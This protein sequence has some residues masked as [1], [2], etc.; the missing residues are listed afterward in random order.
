MNDAESTADKVVNK[1]SMDA[2]D[3]TKV[4]ISYSHDSNHHKQRVLE[5]SDSLVN[6]GIFCIL[7]QYE[8]AP[9]DGWVKWMA[10]SIE[11]SNFILV[12]CTEN[13]ASRSAGNVSI[14]VGKGTKFE[15]LLSFQDLY[16]NDSKNEKIIPIVFYASQSDYIPKPLKPFQYYNLESE[17]GYDD[18]YRRL[19]NQ[20]EITRPNLGEKRKLNTRIN[21]KMA[22]SSVSEQV[23]SCKNGTIEI[24]IDRDFAAYTEKDQQQL[25]NAISELLKIEGGDIRIKGIR[26]GSVIVVLEAPNH[27]VEELK[28]MGNIKKLSNL[29]VVDIRDASV[30]AESLV[31]DTNSSGTVKWF[32]ESKG[33]GFVEREDVAVEP[34]SNIHTGTVK[35]FNEAKGFGFIEQESGPDVFVHFSQITGSGF[36]TLSEGQQVEFEID[37]GEGGDKATHVQIKPA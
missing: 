7:D 14:G 18:L 15:S 1:R 34:R 13:Y 33:Y 22:E 16:D 19:T 3:M 5:L 37:K 31:P 35:W 23:Q 32:N 6:D 11:E 26:K 24:T 2:A 12:I 36:K 20:P 30:T 25:L 10:N 4:F 8:M 28:K 17:N 21:G 9:S 27:I 29:G